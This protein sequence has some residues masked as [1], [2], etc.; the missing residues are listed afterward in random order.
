MKLP[1]RLFIEDKPL[2][3]V[4]IDTIP[5]QFKEDVQKRQIEE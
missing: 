4:V 5:G 2:F 1:E 3:R